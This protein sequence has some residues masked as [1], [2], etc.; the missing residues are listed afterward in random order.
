MVGELHQ[1]LH[2]PVVG[3]PQPEYGTKELA[4]LEYDVTGDRVDGVH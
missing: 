2:N 4:S 3:Y 1:D